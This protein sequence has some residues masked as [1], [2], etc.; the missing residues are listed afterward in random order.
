MSTTPSTGPQTPGGMLPPVA[1]AKKS[2]VLLWILGGCG[3]LILICIIAVAGFSF[4]A[5]NKAKQAGI[6]PELAKK[7]PGLVGARM[8]VAMNKDLEM[9]SSNDAAGTIVVRDKRTGKVTS[10]KFDP[11]KKTMVIVDENGKEGTITLNSGN[12]EMKGPDGTVKIGA[13]TDK[14]P[15]WVPVYPGASPQSVLSASAEG[16]Q[17]G[18]AGFTTPDS[19]EKVMSYYGDQLK[20]GGFKVSTTSNT[21]DG[22]VAGIVNGE[23]KVG[24]RSVLVTATPDD[25][26]TNVSVSFTIKK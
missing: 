13:N 23:D 26:G 25:K 10:M 9:V 15:A 3:T 11:E 20:S 17:T 6:D 7:N 22:K 21:T 1:P 24:K 16:E 19:T 5:M 2:N 4:W 12:V 18:T 14:A 8:A